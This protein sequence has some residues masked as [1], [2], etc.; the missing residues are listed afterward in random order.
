MKK[1]KV[2]ENTVYVFSVKE[3]I[4]KREKQ[5]ISTRLIADNEN[6]QRNFVWGTKKKALLID[7]LLRSD[8]GLIIPPLVGIEKDGVIE[9]ADGQQRVLSVEAF[10]FNKVKLPKGTVIESE[11]ISSKTFAKLPEHLQ[12]KFLETKI[13]VFT[14]SYIS[15]EQTKEMFIRNNAGEKLRPIEK[16]R[17]KISN[18]LTLIK[19][20]TSSGLFEEYIPFSTGELKRFSDV[21]LALSFIME[22]L[23][24]GSDHNKVT[25]DKFAE[26]L[27]Q[28]E[29]E[30]EVQNRIMSKI[31]Y[32][33][34]VFEQVEDNLKEIKDKVLSRSNRIVIYRLT[35]DLL[36]KEYQPKDV[37]NFLTYYFVEKQFNYAI[38]AGTMSTSNKSS[39]DIRYVHI[40]KELNKY[41]KKV[42]KNR[43][44]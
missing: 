8:E 7:T 29:I 42:E 25:K 24:P 43:N 5:E 41:M 35:S 12:E 31:N 3:L 1:I 37:L 26:N 22:E 34:S 32:L 19:T 15:D 10:Y 39:L 2:D 28:I 23:N 14:T 18:K 20:I 17:V 33:N 44:K 9:I 11:D 16:V 36:K 6:I 21:D 13:V 38:V 40:K 4:N 27:S 30:E